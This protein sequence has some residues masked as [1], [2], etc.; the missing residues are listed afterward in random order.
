VLCRVLLHAANLRHFFVS[1]V[2]DKGVVVTF[3]VL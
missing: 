2:S 3:T 1:V